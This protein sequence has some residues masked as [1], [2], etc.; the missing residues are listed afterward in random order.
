MAFNGTASA[1]YVSGTLVD[2]TTDPGTTVTMS[3]DHSA[4]NLTLPDLT[5]NGSLYP[6]VAGPTDAFDNEGG[7]TGGSVT[8]HDT[9]SDNFGDTSSQTGSGPTLPSDTTEFSSGWAPGA[10]DLVINP[11]NCTYQFELSYGVATTTQAGGGPSDPFVEDLVTSPAEPIPANLVL[12]G[13]AQVPEGGNT[14]VSAGGYGPF[15]AYH[16]DW[17]QTFAE[18]FPNS[19]GNGSFTWKLTP[20]YYA[21]QNNPPP[22]NNN[23]TKHCVVPNVKGK[24]KAKAEKAIKK[25]GCKVGKVTKKHSKKVNKGKVVSQSLKAGKKEPVGTKVKLVV[26]SG[27]A[28]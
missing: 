5:A 27:K 2:S 7:P 15:A 24:T 13:S 19:N 9:Y 26:S 22:P 12:E 28:K 8:V 20:T 11:S 21:N 10:N 23:G 3:I 18:S 17:G 14:P 4:S 1:S 16:T 25:A 6:G